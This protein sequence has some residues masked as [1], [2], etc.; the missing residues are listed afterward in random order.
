MQRLRL[1]VCSGARSWIPKVRMRW[2]CGG[3]GRQTWCMILN[4][5][6]GMM[7]LRTIVCRGRRPTGYG[8]IPGNSFIHLIVDAEG[9][10]DGARC[11]DGRFVEQCCADVARC[12][13]PPAAGA[14]EG[15]PRLVH[16]LDALRMCCG[17]GRVGV[18][19]LAIICAV[20]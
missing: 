7:V 19:P 6:F 3:F 20:A 12:T 8:T 1:A 16:R 17:H 13:Y 11:A 18:A 9:P 15:S 14:A 2:T 4:L 5:L 10:R